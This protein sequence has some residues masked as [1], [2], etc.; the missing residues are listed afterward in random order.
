MGGGQ[1]TDDAEY[2]EAFLQQADKVQLVESG[3][4]PLYSTLQECLNYYQSGGNGENDAYYIQFYQTLLRQMEKDAEEQ[5]ARD[6]ANGIMDIVGGARLCYDIINVT[7]K[8]AD[9][10]DIQMSTLVAWPQDGVIEHRADQVV[11]GCH[12]T[13]TDDSERPSNYKKISLATDVYLIAATWASTTLGQSPECLLVMPDYEGYGSTSDRKHPYL[14]RD[15]QARQCVDAVAQACSWYVRHHKGFVPGWT[16]ATLGY[17]QGGAVAAAS[18]RKWLDTP[19]YRQLMPNWVGAVCGDGPYDPYATLKY[20]CDNDRLDMPVAPLLVLKGLCDLDDDMKSVGGQL[21]DFLTADF[22]A[23]G[24]SEAVDAKKYNTNICDDKAF[25]YARRTGKMEMTDDGKL[26]ARSVLRQETFD[27]FA[28]NGKTLPSDPILARKIKTLEHCLKKHSL[29]Y[30]ADGSTWTP[31]AD[32]KFTFF[33]SVR[34]AVVPYANLESVISAWGKDSRQAKYVSYTSNS[35]YSHLD[36]GTQF[37]LFHHKDLV[38]QL[39][40]VGSWQNGVSEIK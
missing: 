6:G 28:S 4:I 12:I 15:L 27:Y 3:S 13:I 2:S 14:I 11:L 20:Y 37:V 40:G 17:S 30:Q 7:T 33:H 23:S 24:I 35:N 16:V 21:S 26:K 1:K 5:A 18:Y 38:N 31:P 36:A 39:F 29:L 32:A 19:E 25:D 9:G 34:D 8:G 10:T 22:L